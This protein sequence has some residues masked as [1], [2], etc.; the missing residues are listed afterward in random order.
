MP[1][2]TDFEEMPELV[3]FLATKDKSQ[4]ISERIARE[5]KTWAETTLRDVDLQL[6]WLRMLLEYGRIVSPVGDF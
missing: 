5:S 6:V 3:R 1:V 2:S 4:E